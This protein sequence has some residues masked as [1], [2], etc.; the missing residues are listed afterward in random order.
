MRDTDAFTRLVD[1]KMLEY[2]L[3]GNVEGI[4]Q[5]AFF[6]LKRG[7]SEG[8]WGDWEDY[9]GFLHLLRESEAKKRGCL[10]R[11]VGRQFGGA[12]CGMVP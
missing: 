9:D 4:S 7:G 1:E 5:E 2:E 12:R 8:V 11:G 6:Y 10:L 3:G